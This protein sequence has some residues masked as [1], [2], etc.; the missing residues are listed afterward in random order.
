VLSHTQ[1]RRSDETCPFSF[2]R[3][4]PTVELGE[5]LKWTT[6]QTQNVKQPTS[7]D[8]AVQCL[9]VVL[10]SSCYRETFSS[11]VN[12]ITTLLEVLRKGTP[13]PQMQYQI[14][15]CIWLLSFEKNVCAQLQKYVG[16]SA[17]RLKGCCVH[18]L[19]LDAT[20][21]YRLFWILHDLL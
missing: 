4:I 6:T 19:F 21:L 1:R 7:T 13:S 15:F 17:M 11:Y 2:L 12:G 8:I 5:F 3:M 18:V 16:D 9:Q 20:M 10:R 14:V